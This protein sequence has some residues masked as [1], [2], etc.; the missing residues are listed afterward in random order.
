[1]E[2]MFMYK[3]LLIPLDERPCN[4]DF[5]QM[6]SAGTDCQLIV[7]PRE[8][9]GKKKQAGNVDAIWQWLID[10]I[11]DC[12]NAV[13]SIDT[14]LYSGIVPSRLHNYSSEFLIKRLDKLREIKKLKPDIRL[15]AFNLIM[16]NPSYSSSDEE[17]DYYGLWGREIHR[18]G[19]ITHKHELGIADDK[20]LSELKSIKK[21]LP[22]EYLEDYY[23]R[24]KINLEVNKEV[25][26]LA[27][28]GVL[29]FVIIPQDDASPYGVTAKDQQIIRSGIDELKVNFK[30][31][32]YPDAD[33][34]A[35]TLLTRVINKIHNRRPFVYVKYASS[36]GG[37][38]IPLYEDRIVSETIKY[39]ILAAGG[40]MASSANEA[41]IILMINVPGGE[42]QDR[43]QEPDP[44]N[45]EIIR[46]TIQYDAF[47]NLIEMIEYAEY[48]IEYKHKNV[49]FGDIAY[50]NGGDDHL[51]SLLQQKELLWKLAGYAGWNTS[52]NT[53]GTC[54]PMGMLH[55]I[56]GTTKES[57]KFLSLRYLEDIAYSVY[58]RQDVTDN[59]I[60]RLGLTREKLD[61]QR[62][63]AS[64]IVWKK[65][66]EFADSNLNDEKHSVIVRDCYMPWNRMFEAGI[67]TDIILK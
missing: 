12:S 62:G 6:L 27:S 41:D 42:M 2:D 66:Q 64:E 26:K 10:N 30:V 54:I 61:G 59:D 28:E 18:Y 34:V 46:H 52:S 37:G 51:F 35:N 3:I 29:D 55:H 56:F 67:R 8:I 9:L 1:M 4:Y 17:P 5:P 50:G 16:R 58:V 14:L 60:L 24:R 25:I 38:V 13:I 47:R 36:I 65:L 23:N 39:Q 57:L 43:L 32:M 63:K 19:Y 15:Y 22:N 21:E 20:E 11:K 49:I 48:Q 45:G 53:L 31:Y 7:P 44:V 40:L 33:A